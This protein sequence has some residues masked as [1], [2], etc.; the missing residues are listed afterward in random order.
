MCDFRH[1][2]PLVLTVFGC[3]WSVLLEVASGDAFRCDIVAGGWGLIWDVQ[4]Q[5]ASV[6]LRLFCA[7]LGFGSTQCE[8]TYDTY[9]HMNL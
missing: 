1:D 6:Q 9:E 5:V 3:V 7:C 8:A 4:L 2:A